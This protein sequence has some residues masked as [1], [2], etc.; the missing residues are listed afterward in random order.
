MGRRKLP[1]GTQRLQRRCLEYGVRRL[2]AAFTIKNAVACRSAGILARMSAKRE[3][4]FGAERACWQ[5]SVLFTQ[6]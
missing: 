3:D 5:D 6:A 4:F 1:T 2:D